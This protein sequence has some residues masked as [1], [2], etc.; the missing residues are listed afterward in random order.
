MSDSGVLGVV[1]WISDDGIRKY[2]CRGSGEKYKQFYIWLKD[3]SYR[4][5][6]TDWPWDYFVFEDVNDHEKLTQEFPNDVWE[7]KND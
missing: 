6:S 2:G 4:C 1:W 7:D 5:T 3:T